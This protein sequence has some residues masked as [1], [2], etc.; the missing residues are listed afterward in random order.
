MLMLELL[1][2]LLRFFLCAAS[3][4]HFHAK[5]SLETELV[6]TLYYG[7]SFCVYLIFNETK[8]QLNLVNCS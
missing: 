4:S 5:K 3:L 7:H 8:S 1:L 2:L 6:A